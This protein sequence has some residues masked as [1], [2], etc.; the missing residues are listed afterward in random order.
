VEE[1]GPRAGDEIALD[2][3][4]AR[5]ELVSVVRAD[6]EGARADRLPYEEGGDIAL[7]ERRGQE[8]RIEVLHRHRLRID[9]ILRQVL[10]DEPR[11]GRADAR[12][13]RLA[14]QVL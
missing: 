14:C 5:G 4:L 13:H 7:A 11:A 8:L 3:A 10:G 9:A 2:I 1:L 6:L 12:R